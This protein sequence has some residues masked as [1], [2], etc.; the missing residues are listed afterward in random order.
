MYVGKKKEVPSPYRT[1]LS[2]SSG[3][4]IMFAGLTGGSRT[5]SIL[6]TFLMFAMIHI[7]LDRRI[8]D[9]QDQKK[10]YV[11][12]KVICPIWDHRTFFYRQPLTWAFYDNPTSESV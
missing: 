9:S 6:Q 11:E 7:G 2:E 10:F 8:L 3:R 5:V 4:I 1:G 12:K